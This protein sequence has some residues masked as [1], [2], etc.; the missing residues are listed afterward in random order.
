M[1]FKFN[2]LRK[3]TVKLQRSNFEAIEDL[4]RNL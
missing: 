2:S 1:D 3:A 4:Q